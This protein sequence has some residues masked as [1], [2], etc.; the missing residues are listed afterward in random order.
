MMVLVG[1]CIAAVPTPSPGIRDPSEKRETRAGLLRAASEVWKPTKIFAA[2][3]E[4]AISTCAFTCGAERA[5]VRDM[6]SRKPGRDDRVDA[7]W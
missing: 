7:G 5:S 2:P 6:V 4:A 1:R 3:F